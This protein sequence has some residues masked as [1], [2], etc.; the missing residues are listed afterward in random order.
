MDAQ[1]SPS[2]PPEPAPPDLGKRYRVE[3]LLGRGGMG[4]VYRCHDH[5]TGRTVALKRLKADAVARRPALSAL[6]E[7]EYHAL[8]ELAHPSIIEVFDYGIGGD[9]APY[10][11]MELLDGQDLSALAPL[12]WQ[13]ACALLRD[14]ASSLAILHSR[15]LL[16]RDVS[17]GNV[18]KDAAGHAKLLDFGAMATFGVEGQIIG[19]PPCIAPEM[20]HNQ[21]LDARADLYSL[22]ALGYF[23]IGG[24]HAYPARRI[25]TLR[26]MW[27]SRPRTLGTLAP[28]TPEE[29]C[30]LIGSMISLD[31]MARPTSAGEVI[32]RLTAI[33][34]LETDE[35][36][37][38]SLEVARAYLKTPTLLGRDAQMGRLRKQVLRAARGRG[39]ASIIDG[40]PGIGRTR[41]LDA[42]ALEGKLA[43]A[44]V[45]TAAGADSTGR[46]FGMIQELAR[47][48]A[49]QL[50][51]AARN[52]FERH[53]NAILAVLPEMAQLLALPER[54]QGP[55]ASRMQNVDSV[56]MAALADW[57]DEITS[58]RPLVIAVDDLQDADEQSQGILGALAHRA[59]QRRLAVVVTI[60]SGQ[61]ESPVVAGLRRVAPV[62]TLAPFDTE[63]TRKLV[64]SLFGDVRHVELV[65]DWVVRL[66]QGKPR[67]C[68]ELCE[69]L[70]ERGIAQ[71]RRGAWV[72]PAS[73]REDELPTS[74]EGALC[75]RVRQLSPDA[76]AIA[77]GIALSTLRLGL[78]EYDQL[79][80]GGEDCHARVFA[81]VGELVA[82]GVLAGD[83]D[84]YRLTQPA[85]RDAIRV[86]VDDEEVVRETHRRLA[87]IFEA[88]GNTFNVADHQLLAGD[89]LDAL[90]SVIEGYHRS[91]QAQASGTYRYQGG[92]GE[93]PALAFETRRELLDVWEK[94][95]R[96]E[97][98]RFILHRSMVMLAHSYN[99]SLARPYIEPLIELLKH[100]LGLHHWHELGTE[101][102]DAERIRDCLAKAQQAYEAAD[103]RD[104]IMPPS[105]AVPAAIVLV[106]MG[107]NTGRQD[108]DA[109]L[110]R[111]L[112]DFVDY[113]R[114][115]SPRLQITR[116][117]IEHSLALVTGRV[118]VAQETRQR[119]FEYY[120]TGALPNPENPLYYVSQIGRAIILH[121]EGYFWAVRGGTRAE[122][123][124]AL[125]AD[126]LQGLPEEGNAVRR[127]GHLWLRRAWEIRHIMH[128]YNGNAKEARRAQDKID[129]LAM[130]RGWAAFGG[131][132]AQFEA[133]AHAVCGDLMALKRSLQTLEA[134]VA[135]GHKGW[136]PF[137]H[138]AR[139]EYQRLRGNPQEAI[140]EC[141]QAL[142]LAAAGEH[143]G[144]SVASVSLV[145]ALLAAGRPDEA[146]A[147]ARQ[148]I[149][150]CKRVNLGPYAEHSIKRVLSLSEAATGS[151]EAA[152]KR[153]E[154]L[155]AAAEAGGVDGATMGHLD[156]TIA[157]ACIYA[158][159]YEG[160]RAA[161]A[162]AGQMYRA[163][164]NPALF[165]KHERLLQAGRAAGFPGDSGRPT[166]PPSG[167][168]I[169]PTGVQ[170]ELAALSD[171]RDRHQV[172]LRVM[173]ERTGAKS[174][175][176]F[177]W[178][179]NALRLGAADD[180][181]EPSKELLDT[182]TEYLKAELDDYPDVTVTCFDHQL[183]EGQAPGFSHPD[184]DYRPVLLTRESG[185]G[186]QVV[187][188]A[189]LLD[190]G[191]GLRMPTLDMISSVTEG[192]HATAT[193]E[194]EV[195]V[196]EL[197]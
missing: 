152:V 184:G 122:P 71:Y 15:R 134:I 68:M 49:A 23:L 115:L 32:E 190:T 194:A 84:E 17:P 6:F 197:S 155:R 12:P 31:A 143:A 149:A 1:A 141:Q 65:A 180:P 100:T 92:F 43:G 150:E 110:L 26:D 95:E 117:A 168:S 181:N 144:W 133:Y 34:G 14:V 86:T 116:D 96:P 20:V 177:L 58:D 114:P 99:A 54:Q 131:G 139:S 118:G 179:D 153:L 135:Q 132:T 47:S 97:R 78:S 57:I 175:F 76:L 189:A 46:P 195:S 178:D 156:E 69:H 56:A 121:A 157:R 7:R 75:E 9:G 145:E 64:R 166:R 186:R 91:T 136:Q 160:F 79:L 44:T 80:A 24:Q 66:A 5:V 10:Y 165:A 125:L 112:L 164:G 67:N 196:F 162:R 62:I 126:P 176:L 159:D 28:D 103:E 173:M 171:E 45:I 98:E 101:A 73:L 35:S 93:D 37:D 60:T 33:A 129:Q 82:A 59:G 8:Q 50:P 51:D 77:Q 70:V 169:E 142:A 94:H 74:F 124:A 119:M 191:E 183:V 21:P 72:L 108:Y 120:K 104:R 18:H 90:R 87:T 11:T 167:L 146:L 89:E 48:L 128:L 22:G 154:R 53:Q 88:R 42:L 163:G 29:L 106:G 38:A 40:E 39:S 16:H 30:S 137:V 182:L 185:Q 2:N 127:S 13:Q 102:S 140:K 109:P 85:Y 188:I 151:A 111:Y 25:E 61:P 113:L 192:L 63:E 41:L 161:A 81:A 55:A 193:D 83:G 130:Q 19:T 158:K 36:L 148:A 123:W 138:I 3:G 4:E 105:E 107:Q 147:T 27:R 174:G 172:A 187:G 170:T 52:H